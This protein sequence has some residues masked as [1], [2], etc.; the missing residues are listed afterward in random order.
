MDGIAG[1]DAERG[2]QA[3]DDARLFAMRD[4]VVPDDV[5]ADVLPGPAGRHGAFDGFDIALGGIGRRV[6]PRVAML[7]QG[8]A[9]ADGVADH[10][11]L[12]DPALAPMRADQPDLLRR[13]RRPGRGGIAQGEAANGDVVP[14]RLVRVKNGAA[15]IDLHL[16]LVRVNIL[17]LRPDRCVRRPW[18]TT[19]RRP[20]PPSGRVR[21]SG[22]QQG[23]RTSSSRAAS[24]SH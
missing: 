16:L 22:R 2:A 10:V 7:A 18:H 9:R 5:M 11:V 20:E 3:A 13:R 24:T 21:A 15:N 14:A 19:T 1:N 6:I 4:G 12:D 17:E 8:D 23:S